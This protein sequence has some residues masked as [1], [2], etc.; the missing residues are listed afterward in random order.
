GSLFVDNI[1]GNILNQAV[2][3][4]NNTS[5]DGLSTSTASSVTVKS[6]RLFRGNS[7]LV[8]SSKDMFHVD[9]TIT[10]GKLD[11]QSVEAIGFNYQRTSDYARLVNVLS[12][13]ANFKV[14]LDGVAVDYT[15]TTLPF[16]IYNYA[17]LIKSIG[18]SFVG[19]LQ[20]SVGNSA[21]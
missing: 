18:L 2:S 7:N 21:G 4:T 20:F 10:S 13:S 6:A 11:L 14:S 3:Q 8:L 12:Q 5:Y 17:S 9:S 16:Y 15:G 19:E 1:N